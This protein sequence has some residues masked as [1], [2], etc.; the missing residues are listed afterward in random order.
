MRLSSKLLIVVLGTLFIG[1][2]LMAGDERDPSEM[3]VK[4]RAAFFASGAER[5][6]ERREVVTGAHHLKRATRSTDPQITAFQR[7][8]RKLNTEYTA[9]KAKF[10]AIKKDHADAAETHKRAQD[11]ARLEALQR[12]AEELK[13]EA[14]ETATMGKEDASSAA[15]R[16]QSIKRVPVT[17]GHVDVTPKTAKI[18]TIEDNAGTAVHTTGPELIQSHLTPA[19]D[20]TEDD[21]FAD[22]YEAARNTDE[23]EDELE[24]PDESTIRGAA[25]K[26]RQEAL[27]GTAPAELGTIEK[28]D[29]EGEEEEGE[30]KREAPAEEEADVE[31]E[32]E[33]E[34]D[35]RLGGMLTVEDEDSWEEAVAPH[36]KPRVE[37]GPRVDPTRRH[38][39]SPTLSHMAAIEESDEEGEE[40]EEGEVKREAPAEREVAE[41]EEAVAAP[42]IELPEGLRTQEE[43]TE[44]LEA[45]ARNRTLDGQLKSWDDLFNKPL[46]D[47][48]VEGS[49]ISRAIGKAWTQFVRSALNSDRKQDKRHLGTIKTTLFD[50]EYLQYI[51]RMYKDHPEDGVTK[52]INTYDPTLL[53]VVE[54]GEASAE[55]EGPAEEHEEVAKEEEEE[56]EFFD[57]EEE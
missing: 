29:E 3:S 41:E 12:A 15:L 4:E 11:S 51:V 34:A 8:L 56:D 19:P 42:A 47:I 20:D 44:T 24:A 49:D 55:G 45:V 54:R 52:G 14:D 16:K 32:G 37:F 18:T 5:H 13:K 36:Y 22:A 43:I 48:D 2:H 17:R 46:E 38:T 31:E 26:A 6:E 7:Q 50:P 21:I 39:P 25:F 1:S 10:E 35:Y 53:T 57:T 33:E 28:S 27:G 40:E 30:V 9:L 23:E